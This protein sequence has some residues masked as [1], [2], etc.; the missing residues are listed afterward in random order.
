M[1]TVKYHTCFLEAL[2]NVYKVFLPSG[3]EKRE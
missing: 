1:V 3:A 2:Q